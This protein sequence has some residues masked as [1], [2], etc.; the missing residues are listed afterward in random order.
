METT[1]L[2]GTLFGLISAVCFGTSDF[3][4]G[5][6]SR[7]ARTPTVLITTQMIGIMTFMLLAL[8]TQDTLPNPGEVL[9]GIVAGC[10]S[11]VV[12]NLFYYAMAYGKISIVAPVATLVTISFPVV[13]SILQEGSP[14]AMTLCGFGLALV[15]VV[16][17]S[18]TE[19]IGRVDWRAL[20]LPVTAGVLAGFMF[21]LISQ[22]T[23]NATYTPL[24]PFRIT[25]LLG[26]ILLAYR[27]GAPRLIPRALLP[28]TLATGI[29]SAAATIFF[30]LSAQVGRLDIASVLSA[31]APTVTVVLAALFLHER[32]NRIQIAGIVL[33]TLATILI[34]T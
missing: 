3:L 14:D 12:G 31:L 25:S 8:A 33:A 20:A 29:S 27:I 9:M 17:V 32:V 5:V 10:L 4:G 7:R 19:Q 21:I 11:V 22:M 28:I 6:V 24:I 23:R 1:S 16:L 2:L 26:N 34:S 18:S 13:F 30:V 15:A